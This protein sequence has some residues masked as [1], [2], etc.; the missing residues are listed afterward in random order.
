[1]KKPAIP[2]NEQARLEKLRSYQVLDTPSEASFDDLAK[3]AAHIAG[4]PI[5]L[6]SLIDADRQWFKARVGLETHETH[7]DISFCGHVV[8]EKQPLVVSDALLDERFADNPLVTGD[9]KVRFYAGFPLETEDGFALGTLCAIDQKTQTLDPTQTAMLALL[10]RQVVDQLELRRH[11]LLLEERNR[12]Y[13]EDAKRARRQ[14]EQLR[15]AAATSRLLAEVVS[16]SEDAI[17]TKTV[18]GK[19]TS[20]NNA[21]ARLFGYSEDEIVGQSVSILFPT[22]RLD[23]EPPL[24]A[25]IK[26]G[27]RI[28]HFETA[29]VTKTGQVVEVSV[30][31]SPLVDANDRLIGASSIVRDI[32]ERKRLER[33]QGEFVSTVSHE[34][35]TPLTSIRGSLGLVAGGLTGELPEEAK[36]YIEMALAN[37]DRLGRLINDILDI[38]KMQA[39]GLDFRLRAI[40]LAAAIRSAIDVNQAF[41][42]AHG[43]HLVLVSPVPPGEVVVDP[44][45]L[46]QVF[47]NLISNA[48]KFGGPGTRV[49]VSVEHTRD[50]FVIGVRDYGPGIPADFRSRIFD[51]FAQADS[52][53]TRS[54]GGTGL[55]LNISK[56]IV[57]RMRGTIG[58]ESAH[59]GGTRFYV[60]LPYLPPVTSE[61]SGRR[62]VLV[63]EDDA[64]ISRL[65]EK[66]LGSADFA[67]HIAPTL[68]RARRLLAVQRYDAVTIDLV[69][70]DGEG[71]A[72]VREVRSMRGMDSV[73]IIIVS[74]SNRRLGQ[75]A[76]LV[77]DV[78]EKPFDEETILLALKRAL[79]APRKAS[80]LPRLLYI[81]Q[82]DD[83][84]RLLGKVM[85]ASWEVV[86]A[87][88]LS[89]ARALLTQKKFDIVLLDLTL[90][91]GSGDELLRLVGDAQV[92]IFSADSVG[93][94]L[95]QRVSAALVTARPSHRNLQESILSLLPRLEDT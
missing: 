95:A 77:S 3:L 67:V 86:S 46:A 38:E 61:R 52:S 42:V 83:V 63:C 79:G 45:R 27:E 30:T 39:G 70:A 92:I 54:K 34:L 73:P 82:N 78:I 62:Q 15:S 47:A 43:T 66:M 7:R 90:P 41:A 48:S 88:T 26:S 9:P 33:M 31:L 35:R 5:A 64:D 44:D 12:F 58:F 21:A 37:S 89:D 80:S 28:K 18:D 93:T 11:N 10:A 84:R 19:I 94:T 14:E 20:W 55:G 68:E 22:D 71:A 49:E 69:L 76:V 36:E 13:A 40:D 60:E 8:A 91:D 32:S 1:M 23:E 85:P 6:V 53:S 57:E 29:R 2:I 65:L 87:P 24:I 50:R 59:G 16:S 4:T 25:H 51:R 74:G 75:S 72:F 56:A 17:F 81:E